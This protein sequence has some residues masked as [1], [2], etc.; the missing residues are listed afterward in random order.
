MLTIIVGCYPVSLL[1][2]IMEVA[3]GH[4]AFAGRKSSGLGNLSSDGT[5]HARDA[6][7]M[8]RFDNGVLATI[9]STDSFGNDFGF[10]IQGDKASLR[11]ITNPWLPVAG[12]NIVEIK[13]YGGEVQRI[14]VPAPLD[15][16]GCQVRLVEQCLSAGSKQASRPSPSWDNS[17]EIMGLLT[18]WENDIKQ[19]S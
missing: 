5:V 12:D 18:E 9:Q 14:V 15:A 11:F 8:V 19:R 16:F 2:F 4:D 1:H 7:L 17:V 10:A 3:F 13:T 6:A